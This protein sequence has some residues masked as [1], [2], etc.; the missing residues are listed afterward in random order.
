MRELRAIAAA[1]AVLATL[2]APAL[3]TQYHVNVAGGADFTAIKPAVQAASEGDTIYIASGTYSGPDNRLISVNSK[4]LKIVGT[5]NV[6]VD[7]EG[8]GWGFAFSGA[9][10]DYSTILTALTIRNGVARDFAEDGGGGILCQSG[11]SPIIEYVTVENCDGVFGGGVKFLNSDA[12]LRYCVIRDCTADYGGALST[13]Y[14]SPLVDLSSFWGNVA[15]VSGGAIRCYSGTPTFDRVNVI[16]NADLS[17]NSAVRFDGST[18]NITNCIVAFSTQ[19]GAIYGGSSGTIDHCMVYG[20]EGGDTLPP[21][22]GDN[23]FEDPYFCD[24]YAYS[25][26]VCAASSA[27]SGVNAWSEEVGYV[28][29]DCDAPCVAP[30]EAS[31][32]GSIKALY[33]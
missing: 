3:G 32:W 9:G 33:R 25:G 4:N 27:L 31:T 30:V 22:A 6:V 10:V 5:A 19:G 17:G 18:P 2:A 14:N 11:A 29:D 24:V 1:V 21:Y 8:Q 20:N 16:L 28:Y 26:G 12:L 13:S 23:L 7:C 15:T